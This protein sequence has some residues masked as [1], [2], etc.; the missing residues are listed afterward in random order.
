M[1]LAP[2][3]RVSPAVLS[4]Y[5]DRPLAELPAGVAT[6]DT[7]DAL[8]ALVAEC[9]WLRVTECWRSYATQAAARARYDR[10]V[11]AG[12]PRPG[13]ATWNGATMKADFVA[14]PGRS[15][16]NAGRA[17]DVWTDKLR[18]ALGVEYLDAFWP[19]AERHGWSPIISRPT[20]GVSESW[21][22]D[23]WGPWLNVKRAHG[24]EVA[25]TCAAL[26]VG[27]APPA[28]QSPA[29]VAQALLL[30]AGYAIALDGDVGPRTIA[31][32]RAAGAPT[33]DLGAAATHLR[34]LPPAVLR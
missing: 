9:P 4:S 21:H 18:G 33:D 28:V 17:I 27:Q 13:S 3:V 19:I 12:K 16:H 31:A 29:R 23:H 10:W 20:E 11:A 5:R 22:F 2:L 15:M 32:L 8:A 25:A 30:R 34:A 1:S 6:Q 7:A 24:Y 14:V 26:D